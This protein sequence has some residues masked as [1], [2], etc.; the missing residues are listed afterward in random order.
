ML[1][2]VHEASI[3]APIVSSNTLL[4]RGVLV[5]T[6]RI[7]NAGLWMKTL[8]YHLPLSPGGD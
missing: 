2:L 8:A 5:G 7:D 1:E 3:I 6:C 4:E